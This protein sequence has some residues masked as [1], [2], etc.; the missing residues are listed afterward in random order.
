MK[1]LEQ[2]TFYHGRKTSGPPARL[3][4]NP[5]G[6]T[7]TCKGHGA[8]TRIVAG[9]RCP[10]PDQTMIREVCSAHDSA[11]ALKSGEPLKHLAQRVQHS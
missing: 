8:E 10:D 11:D 9:N 7:L 3:D 4:S 5:S 6:K 2:V 1:I